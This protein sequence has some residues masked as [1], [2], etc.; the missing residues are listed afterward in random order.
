MLLDY[1]FVIY[2][3]NVFEKAVFSDQVHIHS[4][5]RYCYKGQI[6]GTLYTAHAHPVGMLH[7]LMD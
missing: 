4:F 7:F 5:R 2:T 1:D 3:G 6:Q